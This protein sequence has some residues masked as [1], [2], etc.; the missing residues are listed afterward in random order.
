MCGNYKYRPCPKTWFN[1]VKYPQKCIR[2]YGVT[3]VHVQKHSIVVV[4]AQ[5]HVVTMVY[6]QK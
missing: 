5:K 1:N 3:I 4:Y 2:K 6:V